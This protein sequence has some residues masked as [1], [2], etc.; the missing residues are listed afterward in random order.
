[1]DCSRDSRG[2]GKSGTP[3]DPKAL[4]NAIAIWQNWSASRVSR[5]RYAIKDFGFGL[6]IEGIEGD[7]GTNRSTEHDN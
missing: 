1:M 4:Y 6:D 7:D 2:F 5:G 3:I